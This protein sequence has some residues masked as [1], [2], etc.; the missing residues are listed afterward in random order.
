VLGR[1][2]PTDKLRIAEIGVYKGRMTAMWNVILSNRGLSYEY[3]A[4]DHFLGSPENEKGVDYFGLTMQ[5]LATLFQGRDWLRVVANDSLSEVMKY[6]D[7]YF[8]IV[9]VDAAHEHESVKADIAA[10]LPKVKTGGVIWR[11]LCGGLAW[12]RAGS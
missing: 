1:V 12:R 3:T 5:N 8:D 4:I 7:D 6:P 11:R 10:W 9:Y 2:D